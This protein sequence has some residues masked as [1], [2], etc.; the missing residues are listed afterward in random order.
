MKVT[1]PGVETTAPYE[2]YSGFLDAGKPPSGRGTMYFH[3]IC[4]MSPDWRHKPVSL[5]YNGGPGAATP[6]TLIL[7]VVQWRAMCSHPTASHPRG[8]SLRCAQ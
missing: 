4:A 5:W 2:Y 7:T 6:A 8:R 1:L 3:Y